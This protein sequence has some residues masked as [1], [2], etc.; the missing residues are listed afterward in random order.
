MCWLM[1]PDTSF[2]EL[3]AVTFAGSRVTYGNNTLAGSRWQM[4]RC[5]HRYPVDRESQM[6]QNPLMLS[7]CECNIVYC[8]GSYDGSRLSTCCS[9]NLL[10]RSMLSPQHGQHPSITG[11]FVI[12]YRQQTTSVTS[13]ASM[14]RASTSIMPRRGSPALSAIWTS[15]PIV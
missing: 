6:L 14:T 10:L 5:V 12:W 13:T 7:N 1:L 15:Q 8:R 3:E 2:E 9:S 4:E 11:N